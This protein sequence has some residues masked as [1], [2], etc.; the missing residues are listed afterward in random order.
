MKNM[1]AN[2]PWSWL[3]MTRKKYDTLKPWK[4]CHMSRE[5][6]GKLVLCLPSE[7]IDKMY[8]EARA[9]ILLEAIFDMNKEGTYKTAQHDEI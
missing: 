7:I 4:Q 2:K 1:N 6:F 9:D 3:R 5:Q 8:E